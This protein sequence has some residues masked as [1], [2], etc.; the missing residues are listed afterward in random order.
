MSEEETSNFLGGISYSTEQ[1][2]DIE[3]RSVKHSYELRDKAVRFI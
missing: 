1:E 3:S 2:K